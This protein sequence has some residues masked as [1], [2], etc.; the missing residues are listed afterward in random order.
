MRKT[1][2]ALL[3]GLVFTAVYVRANIADDDDDVD[4]EEV[5]VEAV[6]AKPLVNPCENKVC[7]RGEQCVLDVNRKP[8]CACL[9]SCE[10]E[11]DQRYWVCSTRNVTY[12]S[13]CLLDRDHCLCKRKEKGCSNR[14][15]KRVHLDYFGGCRA[16]TDCPKN[17]FEEFPDRLREWLFIVMKQLAGRDEL[18]EYLDLLE[19]AKEDANHTDALI[20]KF[21][22]LDTS[23]QDRRVSR[24]ELQHT[25]QS[26]KAMEH[27]LV[28][29]LNDC[30]A[31]NDRRITIREWGNCLKADHVKLEN[32]CKAI[33]N[34]RGQK[35]R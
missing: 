2:V 1:I 9:M 31:N 29:F 33:R 12:K 34:A 32:K 17:E 3:L 24:R 21:C 7:R 27:C 28:P 4:E 11:V 23:P 6:E 26:L 15:E 5:D 14:N 22:D 8:S 20:W 30:D 35:R 13:D 10:E 18:N 25:I 16:L 19:S